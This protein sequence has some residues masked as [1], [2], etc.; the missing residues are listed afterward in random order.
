[1]QTASED[2]ILGRVLEGRY[3]V[4]AR[5]AQGGMSTVYTAVDE[6][7]DRQVAV[8]VMADSLSADPAFEGRFAREARMA[9]RLSHPNAVSVYD[10]GCDGGHV[11]LIMELVRGRT[12]R[13]LIRERGALD[14]A[15]AVSIMEPVLGA[16]AAAHRAGLVHRD[17]KPENI[18]LAEDGA[19]KVADF[20]LTHAIDADGASTRT[21]LMMGTVAYCAPEQ[22]SRGSA[23]A[24]SD[25]YAAGI[26]L[27]EL[28][29]GAPPYRGDSALAVAYQHV[30]SDVPPPSTRRSDLA[31]A[32]DDLVRRATAREP[33]ARPLDAG[34]LLA[35][36]HDLRV[37]LG[38]PVVAIRRLP[39]SIDLDR[40]QPL[41]VID[42]SAGRADWAQTATTS[43][44][45]EQGRGW[46]HTAVVG[47]PGQAAPF[48]SP[49]NHRGSPGSTWGSPPAAA[50]TAGPRTREPSKPG[51]RR[52]PRRNTWLIVFL[53]ILLLGLATGS[54][55]WWLVAG[56]YRALPDLTGRTQGAAAAV[57]QGDGFKVNSQVVP[58][59]DETLPS[60]SVLLTRPGAGSH[61]LRGKL[62]TLVVSKGPERF[63]L[64]S[65]VGQTYEQAKQALAALPVQVEQ[66][67]A[68]SD[69][70]GKGLAIASVPGA[71][72]PV[73]RGSTVTIRISSGPPLVPVPDVTNKTQKEANS[74]LNK[75]GFTPSYRQD[76]S[77]TIPAGSVISQNP[78]AGQTLVKFSAVAVVISKGPD[79][80]TIPPLPAGTDAQQASDALTA[81]GL[82][83]TLIRKPKHFWDISGYTVESVSPGPGTQVRVGSAV[84]L[85]I[86]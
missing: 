15:L 22:I 84:I 66:S 26:V 36:L 27:F 28:L 40:T 14:P 6:R 71:G 73:K 47:P 42:P 79:L 44:Q 61:V 41:A 30:N 2:R 29:T 4:Q 67:T 86:K 81:L 51:R 10:H 24:R 49:V 53:V 17:V 55:A 32:L 70:V 23:D 31:P 72:T 75:A 85:T 54:G 21:G 82:Q 46:Q 18:L 77:D 8:K 59:F 52:G 20:G 34:V 76:F 38:L 78:G 11:F 1:V 3:R 12:L 57:L 13:E 64:P 7:L 50:T 60:G 9:V 43:T 35:E 65:V 19:V 5:L 56:R 48:G 83:V 68:P 45:A 62:I 58:Q 39:P 69:T 80:V 37:D 25:V 33:S 16:L 63:T 74:V